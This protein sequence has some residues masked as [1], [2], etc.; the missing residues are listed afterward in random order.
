MTRKQPTLSIGPLSTRGTG[1]H[2][3][4]QV[5]SFDAPDRHCNSLMPTA[6][7]GEI[8]RLMTATVRPGSLRFMEFPSVGQGC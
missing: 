3:A 2:F 4:A 6:A 7:P 8:T 1:Q 5:H